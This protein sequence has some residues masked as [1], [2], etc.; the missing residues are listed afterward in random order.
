MPRPRPEP[1]LETELADWRAANSGELAPSARLLG[2]A[3]SALPSSGVLLRATAAEDA[4]AAAVIVV[5]MT[6][7][8]AIGECNDAGFT[9]H[10]LNFFLDA[11]SAGYL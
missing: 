3:L 7:Y 4:G 10:A 8:F 2:G 9:E 6:Q 5:D 11:D 1:V